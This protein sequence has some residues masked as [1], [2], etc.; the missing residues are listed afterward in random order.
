MKILFGLL[1]FINFAHCQDL[2]DFDAPKGYKKIAHAI[3]DLDNDGK[4]ELV[5]AY[6]TNKRD[7]DSS[8]SRELYICKKQAGK[9]K[10][11]K[12]NT[13]VLWKSG[14]FGFYDTGISLEIENNTIILSQ[15][16][17]SNS[18]HSFEYK[19]IFR[20][21]KNDWFLIG[22]TCTDSYNCM[23]TMTYDIN[24][25]TKKVIADHEFESCEDN[26][27][28]KEDD[29]HWEF[30]YDFKSLPKMDNFTAGKVKHKIPNTK[31][32]FYY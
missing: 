15:T 8:F 10:T 16:F 26:V 1:I 4:D 3:G 17:F 30:T 24:F 22:S 32:H 18:R 9:I 14:D 19:N 11:W 13:S 28:P 25:S 27:E 29:K 20:Y 7:K 5:F 23:W 12:K 6:Q 21:Q 2:K 31:E